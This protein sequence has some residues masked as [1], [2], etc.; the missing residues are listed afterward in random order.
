MEGSIGFLLVV[1]FQEAMF[2]KYFEK[3]NTVQIIK[4]Q[5]D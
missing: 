2:K 3:L 5:R 4:A 1:H